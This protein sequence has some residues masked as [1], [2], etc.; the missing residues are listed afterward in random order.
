M[1]KVRF[2]AAIANTAVGTVR[3]CSD[4][5]ANVLLNAGLVEVVDESGSE[6]E[7]TPEPTREDI[8]AW[9]QANGIECSAKGNLSKA[10][11]EAYEDAHKEG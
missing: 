3:D 6:L 1:P 7:P 10:V 8:R 9:A 2:V 4:S 11:Y 5:E